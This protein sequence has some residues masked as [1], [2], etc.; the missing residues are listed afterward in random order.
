MIGRIDRYG[1]GGIAVEDHMGGVLLS[2]TTANQ[3]SAGYPCTRGGPIPNDHVT[4]GERVSDGDLAGANQSSAG[5]LVT[6]TSFSLPL[7]RQGRITVLH[8]A[9]PK[10]I[11]P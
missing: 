4:G 5:Y 3:S 7:H 6:I 9:M 11:L 10:S 8:S 1:T 2:I